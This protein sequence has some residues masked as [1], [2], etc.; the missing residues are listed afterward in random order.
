V[1]IEPAGSKTS[2]MKN[3]NRQEG[4]MS[5][6]EWIIEPHENLYIMGTAS[7][8]PLVDQTRVT[9]ETNELMIHKGDYEKFFFISDKSER[10]ILFGFDKQLA[11]CFILGPLL[12]IL[13]VILWIV[14]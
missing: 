5:Y 7:T 8:N 14:L 10:Q 1:L 6:Q 9:E 11:V 3:T 4:D 2:I 12:I 13:G